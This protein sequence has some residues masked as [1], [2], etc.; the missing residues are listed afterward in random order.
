MAS[1]V[2]G[3]PKTYDLIR[4]SMQTCFEASR[5]GCSAKQIL[6]KVR[7]AQHHSYGCMTS[8]DKFET[9]HIVYSFHCCP[10]ESALV[11]ASIGFLALN[12][13]K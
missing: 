1:L 8:Q 7:T 4:T 5:P 10:Q 11:V 2:G 6:G 13:R 9:I 12:P 3:E